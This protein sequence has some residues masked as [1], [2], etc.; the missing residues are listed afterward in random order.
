MIDFYTPPCILFADD[1]MDTLAMFAMEI[2]LRQWSGD[3][4]T[5]PRQMFEKIN[6]Q[7][8]QTGKNPYDVIVADINYMDAGPEPHFPRITGIT[9]ALEVRRHYPNIPIVFVTAFSNTLTRLEMK[10]ISNEIMIKPIEIN[11]LFDRLALLVLWHRHIRMDTV[12][13]DRRRQ[14][15]NQT[16]FQRR[17]TDRK[18]Y[19]PPVL[20][21]ALNEVRELQ[22]AHVMAQARS[23]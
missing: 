23:L 16:D 1:D 15:V 12:K 10:K 4:V 3:F 18:L 8:E 2:K 14:S 6:E 19:I 21:S 17:A 22:A 5:S 7:V 20:E 9:A 11:K 13:D